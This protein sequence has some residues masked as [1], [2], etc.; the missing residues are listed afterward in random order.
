ME[1]RKASK[2]DKEKIANLHVASIRKLCGNHY[3]PEQLDAWTNVLVPSVYDQALRE[4]VFLVACGSQKDLLGIGILDVEN[5][6][7]SA[8]YI[9]P[10][11]AG[12]GVG[13]K[14]L[15]ELEKIA[16]NRKL[17]KITINST[18]NAKGFYLINGYLEKELTF[19]NLPNGSKL[20]CV[21]MTKN[22]SK[23]AEP[24]A[25]EGPGKTAGFSKF[26]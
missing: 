8:I 18:L 16:R 11:K 21:R 13:S 17:F 26:Q 6:E 22:L 20:E 15:N 3:T 19:H 2:T 7:I 5:A 10:E 14:L 9:H 1:I 4:K 25:G 24:V 12:N 23:D